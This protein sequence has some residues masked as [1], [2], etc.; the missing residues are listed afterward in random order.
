VNLGGS[1]Y[2][3]PSRSISTQIPST[4]STDDLQDLI[5][6]V[7]N[8]VFLPNTGSRWYRHG[9]EMDY[10][11]PGAAHV[12]AITTIWG[13]GMTSRLWCMPNDRMRVP[14]S[15]KAGTGMGSVARKNEA[16]GT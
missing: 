13:L 16:K 5:N 1:S 4:D 3:T 7:P 12:C 6:V 15:P 9:S 10:A 14:V 11:V 8:K 2:A